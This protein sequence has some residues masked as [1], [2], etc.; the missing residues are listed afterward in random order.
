MRAENAVI[1]LVLLVLHSEVMIYAFRCLIGIVLGFLLIWSFPSYEGYW[2]LL[3]IILVI[4]PEEQDARRIAIER[5]KANL[6]GS[7]VALVIFLLHKPS[8]PVI[9]IGAIAV[10]IICYGFELL[11]VARTAMAT[12]IIVLLYEEKTTWWGS[13][14]RLICV[15]IGCV[16]G[17]GVTLST[18]WIIGKVRFRLQP[19]RYRTQEE[20]EADK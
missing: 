7:S 4:S 10:V 17:L 15:T 3:S 2:T 18:S 11:N 16:I 12:L 13:V 14:E 1:R 20:A 5:M 19:D 9:L 8:L 6:I